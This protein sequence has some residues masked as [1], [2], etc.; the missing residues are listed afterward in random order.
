MVKRLFEMSKNVPLAHCTMITALVL[1]VFGR[2]MVSEP[3]L[4]TLF[5]I[6]VKVAPPSVESKI[7]TFEHENGE[8]SVPATSHVMVCVEFP[9]QEIPE[10]VG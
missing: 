5:A 6:F 3:S 1:G 4:G 2:V 8:R 9:Y 10:A 7:S